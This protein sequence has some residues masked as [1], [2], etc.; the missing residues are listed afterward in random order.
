[1]KL[2]DDNATRTE[3]SGN[4]NKCLFNNQEMAGIHSDTKFCSGKNHSCI[5]EFLTKETKRL[6]HDASK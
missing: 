5:N 6:H 3:G 2:V 4:E 1:M